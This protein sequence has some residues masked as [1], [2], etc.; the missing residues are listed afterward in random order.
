MR[1]LRVDEVEDVDDG[2]ALLLRWVELLPQEGCCRELVALHAEDY[3]Q[4]ALY[5]GGQVVQP[6]LGNVRLDFERD[7]RIPWGLKSWG[8][9][10]HEVAQCG[11]ECRKQVDRF[12]RNGRFDRDL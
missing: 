7:D 2:D 8:V 1:F 12:F 3:P 9:L 5:V 6:G 11:G 10:V 4:A